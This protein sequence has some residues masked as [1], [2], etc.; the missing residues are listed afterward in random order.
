MQVPDVQ[1]RRTKYVYRRTTRAPQNPHTTARFRQPL[2]RTRGATGASRK[3]VWTDCARE[4]ELKEL[5]LQLEQEHAALAREI[6]HRGAGE[7]NQQ[8]AGDGRTSPVLNRA[9]QNV[10]AAAA[11]L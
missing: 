8:I 11:L 1:Q 6:G 4:K 10:A 3:R 9:S 2:R 7:V 5:Q